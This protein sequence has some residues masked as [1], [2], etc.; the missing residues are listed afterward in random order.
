MFQIFVDF[1]VICFRLLFNLLS[2]VDM[3]DAFVRER[4]AF[5]LKTKTPMFYRFCFVLINYVL[6][7]FRNNHIVD[8]HKKALNT[9]QLT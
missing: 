5:V 2:Y 9:R 8:N 7:G 1:T 3:S 6:G 4:R